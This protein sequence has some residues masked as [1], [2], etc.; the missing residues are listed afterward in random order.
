[1]NKNYL[2][3]PPQLP[4]SNS[5]NSSYPYLSQVPTSSGYSTKMALTPI[6]RN[7][8][9]PVATHPA[10]C[11]NSCEYLNRW[12]FGLGRNSN[13]CA[14]K[15][16]AN[17]LRIESPISFRP[18][19]FSFLP[20]VCPPSAPWRGRR[21]D[22]TKA[23]LRNRMRGARNRN[24]VR[25]NDVVSDPV[26]EWEF[27]RDKFWSLVWKCLAF[28][29]QVQ[30]DYFRHCLPLVTLYSR[31]FWSFCQKTKT[32]HFDHFK[33]NIWLVTKIPNWLAICDKRYGALKIQLFINTIPVMLKS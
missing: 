31:T 8:R 14:S 9:S 20:V 13:R 3:P 32:K 29:K 1:M 4:V 19:C 12:Q 15:T 6:W 22:R 28:S 5:I 18:K 27:R 2:P 17:C 7:Y 16:P 24:E 21:N 30:S 25:I 26:D 11:R 23:N 33:E 10:P